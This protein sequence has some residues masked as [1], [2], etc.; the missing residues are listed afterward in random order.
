MW[1]GMPST[2]AAEHIG[3]NPNTYIQGR[4]KRYIHIA[5]AVI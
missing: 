3:L 2:T 4:I 5:L 1:E